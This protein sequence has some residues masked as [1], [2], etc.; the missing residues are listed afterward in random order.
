VS[1]IWAASTS[2][3]L[4]PVPLGSTFTVLIDRGPFAPLKILPNQLTR[5]QV[6]KWAWTMYSRFAVYDG[7]RKLSAS[8]CLNRFGRIDFLSN[9]D[10]A[11][12]SVVGRLLNVAGSWVAADAEGRSDD[13]A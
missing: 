9:V 6:K 12:G 10:T 2:T 7:R 3:K 4:F 13:T 8:I 1:T 5:S 11:T